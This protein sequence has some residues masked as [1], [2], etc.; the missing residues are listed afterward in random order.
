MGSVIWNSDFGGM[1]VARRSWKHVHPNSLR[2]AMELCLEH[3]RDKRNL[4]IDRVADL[5]GQASKWTLYKWMEN[6]RMPA[7]LI[8]PFEHACGIDLITQYLAASAH[9]LV[10]DIPAGKPSDHSTM[11]ELQC[12]FN[13]AMTLL[14]RFYENGAQAPETLA[15]LTEMLTNIAWHRENAAKAVEPELALF[16]EE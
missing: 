10:F 16:S 4:S 1:T 15:A 12:S 3:G 8:R 2:H 7:V 9:K 5:M 11:N 13:G 6:G 14:I